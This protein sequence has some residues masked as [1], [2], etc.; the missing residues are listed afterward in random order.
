MK[1]IIKITYLFLVLI[2]AIS[3]EKDNEILLENSEMNNQKKNLM[4]REEVNPSVWFY[5]TPEEFGCTIL[6]TQNFAETNYS[7]AFAAPIDQYTN[8][9]QF[10][11][12][13]ILPGI[14]FNVANSIHT[15]DA[16]FIPSNSWGYPFVLMSNYDDGELIINFT[17][18]DVKDVSMRLFDM[19]TTDINVTIYGENDHYIAQTLTHYNHPDD[20]AEG[21]FMGLHSDESIKKIVISST[22]G[23]EGVDMISF[24]NCNNPDLDDDGI[25]N[26]DDPFPE[27]N[28]SEYLSIGEHMLEIENIFID[29]GV[30]MMDEIDALINDINEQYNGG[31]WDEL[32]RDFTKELLK[33]TYYWRRDRLITRGERSAIYSAGWRAQVPFNNIPL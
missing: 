19:Q 3:C 4:Q 13:D 27:S 9:L 5:W 11:P 25:L 28:V 17:N 14:L 7:S 29:E 2:I 18:N 8:T 12:G 15:N 22:F 24:G 26:E 10:S 1:H 20:R 30:T 32:H 16:F 31:N 6:P 33:L 23:Y 21:R